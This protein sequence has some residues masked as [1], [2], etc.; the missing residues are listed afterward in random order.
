MQKLWSHLGGL[1]ARLKAALPPAPPP[2]GTV[3]LAMAM[4]RILPKVRP[5]FNYEVFGLRHGNRRPE[6]RVLAGT[7]GQSLVVDFSEGELEVTSA[8]LQ[9]WG[10]TFDVMM[11]QAR[12]NL[13][14]RGSE[15]RFERSR[16]G[17]YRSTWADD[18]DG[19]RILLPGMLKGLRLEGDPVAFL[20]RKD[21]LLVAGSEDRQGLCMALE[22]TLQLLDASPQ[23]LNGC[24]LH[25]QGF[26]WVPLA[27]AED[28]PA[29]PLLRK[30]LGRRL[31]EEYSH[32]K[33]LLDGQHQRE[34]KQI[35]VAPLGMAANDQGRPSSLAHWTREMEGWWLP[36][37][38][39]LC[40]SWNNGQGQNSVWLPWALARRR[41]EP[42]LE[43]LGLFPERHRIRAFPGAALLEDLAA[44]EQSWTTAKVL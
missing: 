7:F 28:H 43:P 44:W 26:Q 4:T 8:H 24:P 21:V 15:E 40:L 17:F 22:A 42:F 33:R 38:D 16:H 23:S 37:A 32:Q 39:Q 27:L 5:R 20:P 34:G 30:V 3:P 25:L 36:E 19:S 14:T 35:G 13:L 41:L 2:R 1:A 10:M 11:N 12:R 6:S 29:L 9:A 31:Q 18:L